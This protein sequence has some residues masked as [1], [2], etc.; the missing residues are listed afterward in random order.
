M[1]KVVKTYIIDYLGTN[2]NLFMPSQ[3]WRLNKHAA[4]ELCIHWCIHGLT[5]DYGIVDI[6]KNILQTI[7]MAN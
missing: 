3:T 4:R 1:A 7:A 2:H 5:V 6:V